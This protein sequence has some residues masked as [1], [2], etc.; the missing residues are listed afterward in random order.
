MEDCLGIAAERFLGL[1]LRGNFFLRQSWPLLTAHVIR[2]NVI[3]LHASWLHNT[4]LTDGRWWWRRCVR[5]GTAIFEQGLVLQRHSSVNTPEVCCC[6]F[7]W[8]ESQEKFQSRWHGDCGI[9]FVSVLCFV[10]YHSPVVLLL[11][12]L[13]LTPCFLWV[14]NTGWHHGSGSTGCR[15]D[16]PGQ[17]VTAHMGAAETCHVLFTCVWNTKW[18][19]QFWEKMIS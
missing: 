11:L 19:I 10:F 7:L 18:I 4:Q 15:Q 16:C 2:C 1:V 17:P 12:I 9:G 13:S 6:H 5:N 3:M 14:L 8:K